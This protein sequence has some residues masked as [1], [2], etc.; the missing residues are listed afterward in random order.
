MNEIEMLH[1]DLVYAYQVGDLDGVAEILEDPRY[2][3]EE[4]DK[5]YARHKEEQE[6]FLGFDQDPILPL[7]S[8]TPSAIVE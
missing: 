1:R 3:T 5:A 8:D 7:P 4:Y 6:A 2:S